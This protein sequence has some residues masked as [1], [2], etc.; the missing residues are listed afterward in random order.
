MKKIAPG[1]ILAI[2]VLG[3]LLEALGMTWNVFEHRELD[4]GEGIVLWQATQVF[5]LKSAFHPLQQYPHIV[6]HYTPLYHIAVRALT[7]LLRDPVLSGRTI[8]LL[9]AFWI[10]GLFAWIIL[11]ATRG[12]ASAGIRCFGA[13]FGGACV[14]TLPAMQWVPF[15]RVD[16]LGLALQFTGLSLIAVK[17][18][19]LRNQIACFCLLLM[20]LYTKQNFIVI[21][22]ASILLIGLI[23]PVR[24][25]WLACGLAT[26]GLSILSILAW[27]TDGGVLKHWIAYNINPFHFQN[28]PAAELQN[29]TNLAALIAAGLAAFWLTFPGAHRNKARNWRASVSA[30]L[31]GSPLRRTGVGFGLVAVL[32]FFN[33]F[34]LG[35]EGAAFNYCLDWQLALCP[36]TGVFVV[37]LSRSWSW[38]DRG[39]A[40]L[41]PLVLLLAGAAGLQLGVQAWIDCDNAVGFT[42][43]TRTNLQ[44]ARRE[45]ADLVKLVSSFP[46]PVVS[47][48]MTVLLRAGKSVP[49]EPAI[50][51]VTTDTGVFDEN[52]LVQKTSDK[53]FDAFILTADV[54]SLRFSP[55]MLQAI[56][57]NYKP[58]DFSGGDYLVFVRQ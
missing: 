28:V 25:M 14:L 31:A 29:S 4:Y 1:I 50:I 11:K 18:F 41:R 54:N 3:A 27:A 33:S 15:A 8:S 38:Q 45:D 12:Y 42:A 26:A 21:P 40:L 17:P 19:R 39:M 5:N 7:G 49:F 47:E 58:Y 36:L 34:G 30:R 24:A 32:G 13:V 57:E 48:N 2:F 56:H 55:R 51:K 22:A 46:G 44:E 23:R 43:A 52:A 9:A 53:F 37:L 16:M 20:G 10:L 35:K 6:F